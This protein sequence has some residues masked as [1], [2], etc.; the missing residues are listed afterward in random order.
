MDSFVNSKLFRLLLCVSLSH[1][2]LPPFLLG[3]FIC[4]YVT[5][6]A[7][8]TQNRCAVVNGIQYNII[9]YY[10]T[11]HNFAPVLIYHVQYTFENVN[12]LKGKHPK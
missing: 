7:W 5:V 1:R 11:K 4:R 8:Q 3:L 9:F 12:M 6:Q 2:L 10:S